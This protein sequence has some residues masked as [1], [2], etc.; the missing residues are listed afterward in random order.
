M[1]I[2]ITGANGQ[3]GR[4]FAEGPNKTGRQLLCLT[5][6]QLDI[7]DPDAV[8]AVLTDRRPALVINAAAYTAVDRAENESE[9]AFLVNEHGCRHL[10]RHCRL[11]D[12][13]LLHI[14]TDYVFD[15]S[16]GAPYLETDPVQPLGIY[17]K[18]KLAGEQAIRELQPRHII[19]RT[20]WVFGTHGHNFVKT[21]L[22]LGKEREELKIVDDQRGGP[23]EAADIA[24][25]LLRIGTIILENGL[26][27]WGTYHFSGK[28][29]TSWFG[30]AQEIFEQAAKTGYRPPRLLPIPTSAYPLPT[31]RPANSVFNCSKIREKF[32]IEQPDWRQSLAKILFELLRKS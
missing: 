12:I 4:Q 15:G 7:T 9:A 31:P 20:S 27:E 5:R 13:P 11:F 16:K 17:G 14:S 23:T 2:L 21:M 22:R 18:S 6:R 1:T 19:L 28:P 25:T 10:A 3:V 30:F 26:I 29:A 24:E 32:G 8:H